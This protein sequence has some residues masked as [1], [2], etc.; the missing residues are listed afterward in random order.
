MDANLAARAEAVQQANT[1]AYW[2][3]IR[4][5]TDDLAGVGPDIVPRAAT[6]PE[7]FQCGRTAVVT[8][9]NGKRFLC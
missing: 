3:I 7:L 4:K 2:T 9:S 6:L 8:A 5:V 1:D